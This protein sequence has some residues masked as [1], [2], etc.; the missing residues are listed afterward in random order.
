MVL[1]CKAVGSFMFV[2][3]QNIRGLAI[4]KAFSIKNILKK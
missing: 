2:Y 4:M 1:K 3:G